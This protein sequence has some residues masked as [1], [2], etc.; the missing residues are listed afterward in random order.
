MKGDKIKYRK[1]YK[2]Q[3][4][5]DYT[6]EVGIF[7]PKS[8][9]TRWCILSNNG[10]LTIMEGYAWDGASGPTFDT[11]SSMRGSLVHDALYQLIRL[12][13]LDISCRPKA[14]D[15]LHDICVEDGMNHARAELWEEMVGLFAGSAAKHDAEPPI[16]EAP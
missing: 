10:F 14:D 11:L 8:I 9:V 4:A 15:R 16:L 1:G 13:K 3:L 6:V 2:Y 5:E 12:G 7:P